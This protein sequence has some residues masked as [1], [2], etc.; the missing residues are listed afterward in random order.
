MKRIIIITA[1]LLGGIGAR[2]EMSKKLK[3]EV[4]STSATEIYNAMDNLIAHK[5]INGFEEINYDCWP[6]GSKM[7]SRNIIEP[8]PSQGPER[9]RL[10]EIF[11]DYCATYDRARPSGSSGARNIIDSISSIRVYSDGVDLEAIEINRKAGRIVMAERREMAM[12]TLKNNIVS[13]GQS[14]TFL[15]GKPEQA[16]LTA[17]TDTLTQLFAT[18]KHSPLAQDSFTTSFIAEAKSS[19]ILRV[20][21]YMK[22]ED[23]TSGEVLCLSG[24]DIEQTWQ[25]IYDTYLRFI[26]Y[27]AD[28]SLTYRRKNLTLMLYSPTN[29]TL[30]AA[31]MK[32]NKIYLFT[33]SYTGNNPYLPANWMISKM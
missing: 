1:L 30:N 5:E 28:I 21:I 7:L 11:K 12:A 15:A 20:R 8:L 17:C 26:G 33:G 18:L 4:N 31:C 2:A 3:N 9:E 29:H 23:V 22:E 13:I 10:K 14:V 27:D 16:A 25:K 19:G 6:N 24:P 32:D